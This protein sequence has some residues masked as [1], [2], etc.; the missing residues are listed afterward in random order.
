[1]FEKAKADQELDKKLREEKVIF[2]LHLLGIDNNGHAFRPSSPEYLNNI[3]IV[4]SGVEQIYHLI[5]KYF[6]YDNRT[7]YVFT[8]DHGMSN[9]GSH[10]DSLPDNTDTPLICWG[11]GIVCISSLFLPLSPLSSF[12]SFPFPF[13]YSFSFAFLF[14][15]PFPFPSSF[16]FP[17]PL[18][19]LFSSLSLSLF[20]CF[21]FPLPLLFPFS[22]SLLPL[23]YS[24]RFSRPLPY[25]PSFF[26]TFLLSPFI[27][28]RVRVLL[29]SFLSREEGRGGRVEGGRKRKGRGRKRGRREGGSWGNLKNKAKHK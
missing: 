1:M 6:N 17:V 21:P 15:F 8:A 10:G 25:S 12:C 13:P 22:L 28:S 26:P 16:P 20:F 3:A 5:E 14:S 18:L 19:F 24:R 2:F 9:K 4:D 27:V 29:L 11:A 7:S 23:S